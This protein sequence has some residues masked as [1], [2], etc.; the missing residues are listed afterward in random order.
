[1]ARR[2]WGRPVVLFAVTAAIG[3]A[4]NLITPWGNHGAAGIL[5]GLSEFMLGCS[6]AWLLESRLS[7]WLRT[8]AGTSLALGALLVACASVVDTGFII[9]FCTAP[10]L[11]ALTGKN[12]VAR[13]FGWGPIHF[14]GE[15]SYSIYLGHFL[16]TA[17]AW[18]LLT[19]QWMNSSLLHAVTGIVFVNGFVI[20]LATLTYYA[21]E[22][23]GRALLSDRHKSAQPLAEIS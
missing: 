16:F 18:R 19:P 1:M 4:C 2:D 6:T 22:R 21:I 15:I 7:A 8:T 10:L 23:P 17:A 9:G 11:L 20:A 13:F 3:F 5:R 14:L 12:P